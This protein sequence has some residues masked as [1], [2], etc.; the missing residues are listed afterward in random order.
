M[1]GTHIV[2]CAMSAALAISFSVQKASS[3]NARDIA[4]MLKTSGSVEVKKTYPGTWQKGIR[5]MRLNSGDQIRTGENSMATLIF[6]DD[7]SLLKIRSSSELTVYGERENRSGKKR[8]T[9]EI[10]QMWAKVQK[11]GSEFRMETP[12]GVA[13]VKGTEWYGMIIEDGSSVFIVL[14]GIVELLNELGQ[15]L[16]GAGQ[17]GTMSKEGAPVVGETGEFEDW[18]KLDDEGLEGEE[19]KMYF[20]D[21]DGNQKVLR[22][23]YR[24]SEG[25]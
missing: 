19:I 10:G 15:E 12:S 8:L 20:E 18:A 6:T 14:D 1:K 4:L 9:M 22:I 24:K 25:Q 5:G 23:R 3:Q 21:A 7:K 13:A 16:V 2:I 11:S 17:T